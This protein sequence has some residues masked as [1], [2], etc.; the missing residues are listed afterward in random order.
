MFSY[1]SILSLSFRFHQIVCSLMQV[2]SDEVHQV[3]Q[4][5][6]AKCSH[7][8][9]THA[10]H[11]M[12][13]ISTYIYSN[14]SWNKT[15]N[16]WQNFIF[17][18]K[19]RQL[20]MMCTWKASWK[21]HRKPSAWNF[22]WNFLQFQYMFSMNSKYVMCIFYILRFQEILFVNNFRL[23]IDKTFWILHW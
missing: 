22:S 3:H 20:Y 14:F 17:R 15:I 23:D 7:N 4:L 2:N 18:R 5:L 19:T 21:Q 12:T 11:F 6:C 13:Y 16:F 1:E 10:F 8:L 9:A